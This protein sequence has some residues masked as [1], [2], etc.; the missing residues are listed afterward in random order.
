MADLVGKTALVT[1]VMD[2]RARHSGDVT[3]G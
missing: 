1:G 2:A 3:R